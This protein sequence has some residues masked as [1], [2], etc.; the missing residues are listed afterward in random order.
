MK[1]TILVDSR[2]RE[3]NSAST[4]DFVVKLGTPIQNV[5]RVD[6]RQLVISEGITNV[7]DT[8]GLFLL[9][10]RYAPVGLAQP[11][12]TSSVNAGYIP[13]GYYTLSQFASALETAMASVVNANSWV[14]IGVPYFTCSVNANRTLE[15][16][17]VNEALEFSLYFPT[18]ECAT[19]FGFASANGKGSD[20]SVDIDG[21]P[22][23]SLV[24]DVPLGLE[25]IEYLMLRSPELGNRLTTARGVPA[26][27]VIPIPDRIRPLVYTRYEAGVSSEIARR[28]L[29][30][31]HLSLTKPNGAVLDLRGNDLA[32]VLDVET[33]ERVNR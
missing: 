16:Y 23:S 2:D 7:S 10:A 4:S 20:V 31:L 1:T 32:I 27:D 15:I 21:N 8:N 6:L 29:Y 26:Y 11:L 22:Y 14:S 18:L 3:A 5:V 25:T 24:A 28:T 9:N 12:T 33:Y 13:A 30:E 17:G 19:L